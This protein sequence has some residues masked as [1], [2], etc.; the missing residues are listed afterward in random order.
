MA[1]LSNLRATARRHSTP[2]SLVILLC[3]VLVFGPR[4][5]DAIRGEPWIDNH[6]TVV[7][8]SGG[9]V[10]VE[11]VT[12]TNAPVQGLRFTSAETVDGTVLCSTE[13]TDIWLGEAKR[14]WR[15][16][17][18]TGCDQPQEPYRV[19]SRFSIRSESDR[20]RSFGPFC[21]PLTKPLDDGD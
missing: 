19:C 20:R 13:Q 11:D 21:S 7:Q 10:V 17:A 1:E 16:P 12:V 5:W 8:N 18:F 15:L 2:G 9:G 6:L 3:A 14:F 4:L